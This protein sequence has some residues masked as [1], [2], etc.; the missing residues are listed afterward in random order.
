MEKMTQTLLFWREASNFAYM[1]GC[2]AKQSEADLVAGALTAV[3]L[4]PE[5]KDSVKWSILFAWTF[6]ESVSDGISGKRIAAKA[7]IT[8]IISG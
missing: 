7:C 4:V 5:L 3:L 8:K 2:S 6:A 1:L